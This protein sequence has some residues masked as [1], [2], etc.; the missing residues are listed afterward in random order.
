MSILG[1]TPPVMKKYDW[2]LPVEGMYDAAILVKPDVVD[3]PN[4]NPETDKPTKKKQLKWKITINHDS[5]LESNPEL[6][7]ED[8]KYSESITYFTG[9]QIGP[10]PKN[11]LTA[12]CKVL[13]PDFDVTVGYAS[14]E[15]FYAKMIG[16]PVRVVT[17]N[18]LAKNGNTYMNVSAFL[19]SNKPRASVADMLKAQ[20]GGK[21]GEDEIPF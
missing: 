9:T 21:V 2:I 4:Y 12:L 8:E 6:T 5:I 15:E 13:D 11:K 7:G 16:A 19:K 20:T 1:L 3:N 10:H 14:E 17:V 18:Q